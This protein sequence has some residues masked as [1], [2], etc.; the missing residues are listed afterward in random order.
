M[1]HKIEEDQEKGVEKVR[2]IEKYFLERWCI[3]K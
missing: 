3:L 2:T 1:Q